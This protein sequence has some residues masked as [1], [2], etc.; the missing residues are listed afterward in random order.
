VRS[1]GLG[2]SSILI[3]RKH[4]PEKVLPFMVWSMERGRKRGP[5]R[6]H[7]TQQRS[8]TVQQ[9]KAASLLGAHGLEEGPSPKAMGSGRPGSHHLTV[10]SRR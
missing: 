5:L 3:S 4:V 8:L 9:V 1:G 7:T 6:H 10:T 2:N